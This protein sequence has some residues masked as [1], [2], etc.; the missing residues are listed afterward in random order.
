MVEIYIL[1]LRTCDPQRSVHSR[2][3]VSA[4]SS[5]PPNSAPFCWIYD[6]GYTFPRVHA[7]HASGAFRVVVPV[8]NR[9]ETRALNVTT[10]LPRRFVLVGSMVAVSANVTFTSNRNSCDWNDRDTVFQICTVKGC[11]TP[12]LDFRAFL[13]SER[14]VKRWVWLIVFGVPLLILFLA[15]ALMFGDASKGEKAKVE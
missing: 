5:L 14:N 1:P 10:E 2:S 6:F 15:L 12:D 3:V 9:I 7:V 11:V 4:V 8:D 13:K